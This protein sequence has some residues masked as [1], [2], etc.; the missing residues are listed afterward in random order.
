MDQTR[1]HN[2]LVTDKFADTDAQSA[3]GCYQYVQKLTPG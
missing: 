2:E 3:N 1:T